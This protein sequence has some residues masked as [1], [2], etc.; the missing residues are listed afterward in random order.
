MEYATWLTD[1][2]RLRDYRLYY[3]SSVSYDKAFETKEAKWI[4]D[5]WIIFEKSS[6]EKNCHMVA[7]NL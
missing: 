3:Y 7:I 2:I 5:N 1:L 6:A 4:Q